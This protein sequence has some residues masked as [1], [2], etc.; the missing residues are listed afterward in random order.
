[1]SDAITFEQAVAWVGSENI[2]QASVFHV[3]IPLKRAYALSFGTLHNFD[4]I[5][6]RLDT[7]TSVLWGESTP[8]PGYGWEGP[9]DVWETS[10]KAAGETV[11]LSSDEAFSKLL[12]MSR[13]APFG[14]A[15]VIGALEQKS[16]HDYLERAFTV[17]TIGILQAETVEELGE[18]TGLLGRSGFDTLK[19]K[20]GRDVESD[21]RRIETVLENLN[22]AQRLRIDANQGLDRGGAARLWDV[23]NHPAVEYL[24][25]PFP[26]RDW[27][28]V[29][30][31]LNVRPNARI[32]LDE[33]VWL[34][35]DLDRVEEL[36][37]DVA[38][39][40]KLM[41]HASAMRTWSMVR[42]LQKSEY[43]VTLGNGV[44]G[45][46]GTLAEIGLYRRLG[47]ES[48]VESNGFAKQAVNLVK[49]FPMSIGN[50]CIACS[51][52]DGE[53]AMSEDFERRV[54]RKWQGT[55]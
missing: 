40:V 50:G 13:T 9:E 11:G 22:A 5:L 43:R 41:K 20:V 49:D 14:L 7:E 47:L 34:D 16:L 23:S 36:D 37:G 2:R 6:C 12:R 29:E 33:S 15:A 42:R 21:I 1:V 35:E 52:W 45:E 26:S 3:R 30:W 18:Q 32:C 46:L 28:S 53:I 55:A 8:L 19:M 31:L 44:Q 24:E 17:P 38:V 48:P 51:Q 54:V 10:L 4:T 27:E 25:Q 39:K